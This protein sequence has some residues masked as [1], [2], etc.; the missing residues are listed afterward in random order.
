M[1][2]KAT[3]VMDLYYNQGKNV[4][5]IA[6]E[7]RISFR[8][9]GAILRKAAVNDGGG[10]GNGRIIMENQGNGNEIMENQ[11]QQQSNGN[12]NNNKPRKYF[13]LSF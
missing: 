5:E 1:V 7:A 2:D 11:Q 6:Q 8:D 10:N 12:N 3:I 13:I 9:I 4:L